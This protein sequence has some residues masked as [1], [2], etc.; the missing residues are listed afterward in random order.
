[1]HSA[2]L[3]IVFAPTLLRPREETVQTMMND[4]TATTEIVKFAIDNYKALYPEVF[5]SYQLDSTHPITGKE[6][7]NCVCYQVS[8]FSIQAW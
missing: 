6:H 1:M 2:N 4:A 8:T 7:P 3:A 5:S